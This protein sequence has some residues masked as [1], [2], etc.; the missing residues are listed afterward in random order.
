MTIFWEFVFILWKTGYGTHKYY[1]CAGNQNS[2]LLFFSGYQTLLMNSR[3]TTQIAFID[4]IN[5]YEGE[6][7][8][9]LVDT[10]LFSNNIYELFF[11]CDCHCINLLKNWE[12]F[13]RVVKIEYVC[14]IIITT[15]KW[16]NEWLG[17]VFFS[18]RSFVRS[19][20]STFWNVSTA[21]LVDLLWFFISLSALALNKMK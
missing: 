16:H 3:L 8:Q 2:T 9:I 19:M 1:Y 4:I 5:V 10:Y 14:T 21:N 15:E 18:V 13:F 11:F 12:I 20:S 17:V 6:K 7:W